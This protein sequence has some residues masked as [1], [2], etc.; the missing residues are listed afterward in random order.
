MYESNEHSII[1]AEILHRA[2]CAVGYMKMQID[3]Y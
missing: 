1:Y 2:Q 3:D